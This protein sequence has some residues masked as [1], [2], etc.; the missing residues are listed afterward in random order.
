MKRIFVL[1]FTTML[2]GQ[3]WAEDNYDFSA[4]CE[5][6]QTLYYK[7]TSATEVSVVY[8]NYSENDYYSGYTKPSGIL[9]IPQ[10]VTNDNITYSVTSIG[11]CAFIGCKGLTS[12]TIP[13]SITSIGNSAFSRCS[14]LISITIPNSVTSIGNAAFGYC[15]G[16]ISITIPNSVT[17]IGL[18]T[19]GGCY[20]LTNINVETG[21]TNYSSEDGVLFNYNKTTIICY[22]A[23]K[24]GISYIIPNSVTSIYDRA[25]EGCSCLTSVSIPNTVIYIGGGAFIDCKGLTSA[26]IPNSVTS[27]GNYTFHGCSGLISITIPNSVTS[28]GSYA[29]HLCSSLTSVSIPN[30]VT[31]I[32]IRAFMEC[33]SLTSLT[34][35]NS[36]TSIGER[37]FHG[38]SSLTSVVLGNSVTSI[39]DYA[40]HSCSSLT[41]VNIPNSVTSIGLGVFEKCF[42][43]TSVTIPNSVTSIGNGALWMCSS[44]TSITIPNSVT[45]IG[46]NAFYGCSG[47][48]SVIIGNSVK[49]IGNNA[50]IGCNNLTAIAYVGTNNPTIGTNSFNGVSNSVK[51]CVP[52]KYSSTSFGGK[53]VCNGLVYDNATE[54]TCTET[55][56]TDGWHCSTCGKEYKEVIP[57]L[58]HNYGAPTY[59]WSNDNSTC[60]ATKV[61]ANDSEHVV[62]ETVNA[63]SAVTEEAT[64]EEVGTRTFTAEFAEEGFATQQTTEEIVAIG[65]NYS[66]PTYIWSEGN[67]TCT[68]TKVCANDNEHVVTETVNATSVVAEEATCEEVGTRTFTAEFTEEGFTTQQTTED[69]PA[70]GHDYGDASYEWAE[71]GSTCSATAICQRDES[72]VATDNAT[73]TSEVTTAA[74]CEGEGTTTYTA[75]FE[76]ELFST[77]TKAVVDILATGHTE[78]IDAAVAPTCLKTGL[79]EGKHCSVCEAVIVAQEIIPALG[80]EFKTYTFDNNATTEADGTE[81]A[82]CEHGCGATDT[83]TAAGTKISTTPEKGTAVTETAAGNVNIYAHGRT[84]V[85]ENAQDEISVYDAMGRLICRDATPSVRNELMVNTAGVYIVK[86][87]KVAKRVVV[88]D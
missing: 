51:V 36:V 21:N 28:I 22:P 11:V 54:P 23:A 6:E 58:G 2:A 9:D 65:H 69:I 73:I 62:T 43:M 25:F 48:T 66:A 38:C 33:S 31:S 45:S 29:F 1:C 82:A 56:L 42:N 63:T 76:N 19:F 81:T 83:R 44:L 60:T 78:A 12:V 39:G 67:S 15:S 7:I 87:G 10:T 50:F 53:K 34:I 20:S 55:G 74:T 17:S 37:A 70:L 68:A 30:S 64:C 3:A 86:V 84:I 18:E 35:P 71:D 57:A 5:S 13:N 79:S 4:V 52:K 46:D 49:K 16:L 88:N 61:C 85:V 27:I 77:Q 41:S 14:G 72:H 80:H 24:A 8:P 26:T 59:T 40:F 75:T 47:L 32:G